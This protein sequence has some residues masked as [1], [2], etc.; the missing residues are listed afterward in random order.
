M[1]MGEFQREKF[2]PDERERA[3]VMP[4]VVDFLII[5]GLSI[6]T[7]IASVGIWAWWHGVIV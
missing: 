4:F 1:V 2:Y 3:K 6:A 7:A 5:A